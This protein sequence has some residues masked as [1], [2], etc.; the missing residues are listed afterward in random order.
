MSP[1]PGTFG[2][3]RRALRTPLLLAALLGVFYA[4]LAHPGAILV[5]RDMLRYHLPMRAGLAHLASAGLPQWDPFAHGGQPLLSNPN[6]G[7]LY[8]LSWLTLIFPP[9][10]ALNWLVL[11]HAALA[12]W[13][14]LRLARRLGA[15]DGAAVLAAVA[16]ACGPTFL[17][18]L[19]TLNIAL[20]MSFLPWAMELGLAVLD[21]RQEDRS[22]AAWLGLSLVLA[23]IFILGDPLIVAMT[24]LTLAAFVLGKPAA[25]LSRLPRLAGAFAFA[26]GLG[27]VQLVPTLARL[28]DSP[29]GAG[30]GWEQST[31]W[32][33][34]WQ[35]VAE[36]VYPTFFGD[37]AR[38]E[39]ALYFGWGIHDQDFPYLVLIAVGLPLLLLS[40]DSWTRRDAPER[41]SWAWISIAGIFLA[42]GRHNPFYRWAWSY[43]PGVDKLRYPEKFL[44][45]ALTAAVFAGALGWQR[46]LDQRGH[47]DRGRALAAELPMALAALLVALAGGFVG[48]TFGAPHLIAWFANAH[49]FPPLAGP[50]LERAL[51][52]YRHESLFALAFALGAF[53]LF[54]LARFS[55]TPRRVLEGG[56]IALVA[57]ELWTYGHALLGTFP[58]RDLFSPP[59][60]ARDLPPSAG[61]LFSDEPYRT[62]KTE[63]VFIAGNS[64]LLWARAPIERLDSRA[65]NLFGYAYAL[66]RD[67]DL[68]LTRPAARAL[69]FFEQI[70]ERPELALH[71]LGAWSVSHLVER[72]PTAELVE[73]ARTVGPQLA[74]TITPVRVR[75]NGFALPPYRFIAGA[76]FSPDADAAERAAVADNLPLNSIEYL[77]ASAWMPPGVP[78]GALPTLPAGRLDDARIRSVEDHGDRVRLAYGAQRPA[79]LVVA[80]T[81]DSRWQAHAGESALPIFETAA[82]YMALLVP[83][84]EH[85]VTLRFRDPW[86]T[87]GAAV[88]ATTIL[89]ALGF[90]L[91]SRRA[92][93]AH[94]AADP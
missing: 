61:R 11:I 46:L 62:D 26:L 73:E 70:R 14:A 74:S 27:A 84:G 56:A 83:A 59:R 75:P 89:L 81:F 47:H 30:V 21:A 35:R 58:S 5:T 4:P 39:R 85:A 64:S 78:S 67:F 50:A 94:I 66:D 76:R 1:G 69:R 37:S 80:S 40:L 42:L 63:L 3:R 92:R 24:L 36:L 54:A 87:V 20:A 33:L 51:A 6:Y 32:S 23:A 72:K 8:P 57:L 41:A 60:I 82:G 34:P 29:R 43:L 17:S 93:A 13:G 16:Y 15:G 31:A 45:L 53:T 71:L 25:R 88:T 38:P 9:A 44:L 19:H 77:I 79:L 28:A 65:G 68:S 12:A 48:L 10:M 49:R 7:A 18:L 91:R 55:R 2:V 90:A 52:F 22:L 86:V